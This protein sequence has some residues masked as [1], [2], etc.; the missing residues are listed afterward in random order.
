[1]SLIPSRISELGLAAIHQKVL[2][3]KRLSFEDGVRLYECPDLTVVGLLANIA[4]ER[5][6][7]NRCYYVRNQH[8]NYTNVCRSRCRFCSFSVRPEDGRAYVL[9]IQQVRER[10]ASCLSLPVS[11]IH[12]VGGV[13]PNLPY[14]YYLDLLRAV[15]E[16]R[17]GVCIKA[18]T[19]VELADIAQKAGK[20]LE[21]TLVELKQAGLDSI[22]GGGAEVFSKRV[23][24]ELFPNKPGADEWLEIARTAHRVGLRSNAT[25]LYGHI[26]TVQEKVSH[27]LRLRQLQ[28]ETGGFYAYL[29]LHFRPANTGLAGKVEEATGEQ[30]LRETALGRLMLDNFD[31]IKSFWVM[32]TPPV[33]QIAQWYGADDIDGTVVEYEIT[34]DP[35]RDT[36]QRLTHRQLL[37]LI[38]EAGRDPFER[39][40][41]CQAVPSG[42]AQFG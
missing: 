29:P 38:K 8:I 27:L 25:M 2:G 36:K 37:H 11:E 41:K 33:A 35:L 12:I 10:V 19:M 39:D 3:G 40:G 30:D 21:T 6:H 5:K 1:M 28:D 7:G 23:R 9:S 34:R 14:S 20:P 24:Q 26:E 15:K 4:R 16:T 17:P 13:N 18:F 42:S 32:I 22:P 31:H